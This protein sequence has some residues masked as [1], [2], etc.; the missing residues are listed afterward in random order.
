MPP[1]SDSALLRAPPWVVPFRSDDL[2]EVRAFIGQRDGPNSRVARRGVP[3]GYSVFALKG[4]RTNLV[5]SE[6]AVAQ[7]VRGNVQGSV[8]LLSVPTGSV[9]RTG[10]RS[11]AP[12]GASSVVVVPPL[13]EYTRASPPGRL[14]AMEIQQKALLGEW[15]ARRATTRP[16][17]AQRLTVLDLPPAERSRLVA[18]GV[19]VLQAT[20]PGLAGRRLELAEARFVEQLAGLFLRDPIRQRP[21]DMTLA[22]AA[23]LEGW[24]DANLDAPITLGRLCQEAGVGERCLQ[25]TF[26]YR[27][28]MSPMRFV[29]ERRLMAVHQRLNQQAVADGF[30]ITSTALALGFT[31]LGRFAQ[32]YRQVIGELP[33]Q[34]LAG[35]QA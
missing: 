9:Y 19:E 30:T 17:R 21:G 3:L 7:T 6:S 4:R 22:R 10:Q 15:E 31:H 13:W 23:D 28:G 34:T 29:L 26:E 2:D 8:V 33:S 24:I 11:L 1:P 5:G 25:K 20:Q 18:A 32:V 35:R 27:R 16:G 14:F 12:T